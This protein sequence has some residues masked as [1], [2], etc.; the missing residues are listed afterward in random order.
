MQARKAL[1]KQ[2]ATAPEWSVTSRAAFGGE[3][4]LESRNTLYRFRDGVCLEV[5]CRDPGKAARARTLVGMR[6]VGWLAGPNA[7]LTTAWAPG[8][9]G[10]LWRPPDEKGEE[11][12]AMTSRSIG[13]TR[14]T[15]H[16]HLQALRD[17]APPADSQTFPRAE[18]VPEAP[19]P[20][21]SSSSHGSR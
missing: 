4:W 19:R 8:A 10:V 6:L 2:L 14:G 12:L 20:R 11:S 7:L 21:F 1:L 13:F 16:V 3:T 15:S 9:C 18:A 5:G 17:Q